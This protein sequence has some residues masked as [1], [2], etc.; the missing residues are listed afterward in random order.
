[1]EKGACPLFSP[2]FFGISPHHLEK[3]F[4]CTFAL[5]A[6]IWIMS[7]PKNRLLFKGLTSIEKEGKL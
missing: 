3:H 2:F 4:S 6:F 1:M 7:D 5:I